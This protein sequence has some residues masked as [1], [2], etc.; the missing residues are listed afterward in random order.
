MARKIIPIL[1]IILGLVILI[2]VVMVSGYIVKLSILNPDITLNEPGS[3]HWLIGSCTDD[4]HECNELNKLTFSNVIYVSDDW[5]ITPTKSNNYVVFDYCRDIIEMRPS[6]TQTTWEYFFHLPHYRYATY[7][8]CTMN[9]QLTS[10][11]V[12]GNGCT[13]KSWSW[14]DGVKNHK[15]PVSGDGCGLKD[16][17]SANYWPGDNDLAGPYSHS[18]GGSE[19]EL[20]WGCHQEINIYYQGELLDAIEQP[21]SGGFVIDMDN[22]IVYDDYSDEVI[23]NTKNFMRIRNINSKYI[24]EPY[25]QCDYYRNEIIWMQRECLVDSECN[26]NDAYTL[27]D[28]CLDYKCVFSE[29]VECLSDEDCNDSNPYTLTDMCIDNKCINSDPVTCISDDDCQYY[30]ECID[31]NCKT[32]YNYLDDDGDRIV[33]KDDKCINVYG[34]KKDGCPTL[35][36]QIMT[37]LQMIWKMIFK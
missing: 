16:G 12:D 6:P 31:N 33:N 13:S 30:E 10:E 4:S 24:P 18:S 2:S 9:Y 19:L 14:Y 28:T 29:P 11:I 17:W 8:S 34:S 7:D 5:I 3:I 15:Y 35:Y 36:E 20:I 23:A 32:Q 25:Y 22:K 27:F 1:G 21:D 26:D 37:L